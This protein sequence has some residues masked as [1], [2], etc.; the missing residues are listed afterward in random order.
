MY[1]YMYF[2]N[3]YFWLCLHVLLQTILNVTFSHS[4]TLFLPMPYVLYKLLMFYLLKE[5][6]I[7]ELW[8]LLLLFITI[9]CHCAFVSFQVKFKMAE[10]MHLLAEWY[11]FV[12]IVILLNFSIYYSILSNWTFQMHTMPAQIYTLFFLKWWYENNLFYIDVVL[13]LLLYFVVASCLSFTNRCCLP[14]LIFAKLLWKNKNAME[15]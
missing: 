13:A 11:Y 1:V 5:A 3:N 6:W 7:W 2:V 12:M 8:S 4:S 10:T 15:I 14:D 9:F